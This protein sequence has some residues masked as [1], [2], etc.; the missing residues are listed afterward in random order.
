M[1]RLWVIHFLRDRKRRL[2][3]FLWLVCVLLCNRSFPAVRLAPAARFPPSFF[4]SFYSAHKFVHRF[5]LIMLLLFAL[6]STSCSPAIYFPLIWFKFYFTW[7]GVPGR[8]VRWSAPG[9]VQLS[10]HRLDRRRNR[11]HSLRLYPAR[12]R[13]SCQHRSQTH[14]S[15][16]E[17]VSM[18]RIKA[19][20]PSGGCNRWGTLTFRLITLKRLDVQFWKFACW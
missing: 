2:F 7:T 9:L 6:L 10:G 20:V 12:H 1:T 8:T 3:T 15:E 5:L 14:V 16:G 11:C 17:L 18:S 4:R 19:V 13:L